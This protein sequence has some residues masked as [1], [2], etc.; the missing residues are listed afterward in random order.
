MSHVD[1]APL[2]L[3]AGS[4]HSAVSAPAYATADAGDASVRPANGRARGRPKG[5]RNKT[6]LEIQSA[7]KRYGTR[8][9]RA[10]A[11]IAMRSPLE[12]MRYRAWCQLLDRGYGK[13]VQASEIS[14][15][16][17]GPIAMAV[18]CEW[19]NQELARRVAIMLGVPAT[20]IEHT[21]RL[22][23][24]APASPAELAGPLIDEDGC[25][26]NGDGTWSVP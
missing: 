26:D 18:E 15:P 4:P 13:P 10:I 17:S 19:S 9:L 21:P 2:S 1:V 3:P 14:G 6:T 5:S 20:T 12:E 8:A 23:S 24:L 22:A 16:A 7:A 11:K 25:I